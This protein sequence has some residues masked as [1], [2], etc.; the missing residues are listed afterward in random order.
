MV[1]FA[2]M[3]TKKRILVV[4][5]EPGILRFVNASLGLAGYEVL[6]AATGEEALLLARSEKLDA[7][8]LDI[9]MVPMSGFDVLTELRTFS[10]IPVIVFSARSYISEQALKAGAN[11]YISKPF[12]PEE[13]VKKLQTVLDK[14]S[15]PKTRK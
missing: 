5:D 4:D 7:M 10:Q 12:R 6:S 11:D 1:K 2:S 8:L 14:A 9:L 13:L 15:R 3:D